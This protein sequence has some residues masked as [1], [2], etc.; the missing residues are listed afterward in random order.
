MEALLTGLAPDKD[1]Y[2]SVGGHVD[3][4]Q[5]FITAPNSNKPPKDGNTHILIVGD[6]GTITDGISEEFPDG[7]YPGQAQAVL[8]GYYAYSE[9]NGGED[10]D[11][12]LALGDNAYEAGPDE[13][14][15]KSFFELYTDI[16]K[17]AATLPTI[18][19]HEMGFGVIE[20]PGSLVCAIAGIPAESC[21][22]PPNDLVPLPLAGGSASP[23]P[24]S[25]DGN[26]D[27][28]PDGSGIPYQD[29]FSL[30]AAGESGG[31]ASG[32]EQYYSVDYGN[33]HVVSLD[34]QLTAR[35]ATARAT[36][37]Q[38]LVNDLMTNTRDWTIVIYHHP[39]YSK[40]TIHDSD[41]TVDS[42]IDRPMWDMRV[43]FT[44]I[45]E[46][47][48]VEARQILEDLLGKYTEYGATQFE[49]P[50]VLEVPPI[51]AFGNVIEIAKL[52]GGAT[53]LRTAVNQ[54]QALLY[55]A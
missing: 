53:K 39:P 35:D 6:S 18:G 48:G 23:D 14:W 27:L 54:L 51:N 9:D 38:W 46:Q 8:E 29:I 49:G 5:H 21:P 45:F 31:V 17:S 33:V 30:P 20:L 2:Y 55:A 15:Q 37:E 19:N 28:Q 36:M 26:G 7:E 50:D 24:A 11:L 52:F 22:F 25:Y 43:E 40:G 4:G 12:F 47:Y 34:S 13:E 1:Y 3:E 32:T 44:P 41:D 16:L 42:P 10:V